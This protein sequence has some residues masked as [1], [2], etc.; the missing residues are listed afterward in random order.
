MKAAA[1]SSKMKLPEL[2]LHPESDE[3]L[4][5][6]EHDGDEITSETPSER[7]LILVKNH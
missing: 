5:L 2:F 1:Y 3:V 7:N 6:V 4:D